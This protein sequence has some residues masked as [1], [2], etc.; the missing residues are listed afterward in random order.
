MRPDPERWGLETRYR[1]AFGEW[2]EA[3]AATVEAVLD[4]MGADAEGPPGPDPWAARPPAARC[5]LPADAPAWG[6]AAQLYAARSS[7]SWGIGDLGDL[8]ALGR[9]AAALGAGFIL[10]NPL[11]AAAPTLPQSPSPYFPSS[12]RFR[13][14]LY[15]RVEDVPGA[16]SNI[17][18]A[19]KAGRVL[20]GRRLIDRDAVFRIKLAKQFGVSDLGNRFFSHVFVAAKAAARQRARRP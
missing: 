14:P 8:D 4:A 2:L 17:E 3:P 16:G 11:H 5:P 9:W 13:N 12:R 1:D 20:N 19:A 7:R 10:V 6:W 15:L 18:A